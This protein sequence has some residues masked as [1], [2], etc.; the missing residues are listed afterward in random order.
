MEENKQ[1]DKKSIK[2]LKASKIDW[3]ELAKD[4]VCFANGKGGKILLGI[5]DGENTPPPDQE[6]PKANYDQKIQ[7]AIQQRTQNVAITVAPLTASNGG[8]YIEIKILSSSKSIAATSDGRYY[9]RVSDECQP[10]MPEDMGRLAT[11]KDAFV[12][13]LQTN[14]KVPANRV[15]QPKFY[16]IIEQIRSSE[17]VSSFF[18]EKSDDELLEEYFL[19]NEEYLTNL[20]V[21]WIGKRKD[22][23]R[24]RYAP[25]L[26]FIRYDDQ[27][28][29]VKKLTWDDFSYNPQELLESVIQDIPDWQESFE[30]P[31]GIFRTD[32]PHFE[33]EVIRELVAN[34]LVH[35]NYAMQGDI[36]IN[37]YPDHLEIHSPGRLPL[38]V[39][40]ENILHKSVRR[41]EHLARLFY[42]LGLMEREG[43]GYDKVYELLL[44][45]GRPVPNVIDKD[46]RLVVNIK[47]QIINQEIIKL[48]EK[49]STDFQLRQREVI[50]LGLIAQHNVISALDLSKLLNQKDETGLKDWLGRLRELEIIQHKGKK[51][52]TEYFVNPELLKKVNFKGK[53]DLKRIGKPRLK[54]LILEDLKIYSESSISDIHNRVGPELKRRTVKQAIDEMLK[55]E[56]IDTKGAKRWRR[57]F[58]KS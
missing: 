15:D 40:P 6:I 9:M 27:E 17:R 23:A 13:E 54:E 51:R 48:I 1:L 32:I 18:K 19:K 44:S 12:W 11:E 4:C 52:S 30:I 49:A 7:K 16:R 57:Y 31:E 2:T 33:V 29:K 36:F 26:Q 21:L 55:E 3:G 50:S 37:L 41:N 34:A 35:R 53:T 20:G 47:K 28:K 14:L 45:S 58:V 39:T 24:L 56:K 8:E 38:G 5:E 42:D 22:R 10:V 43:S 46:D 25:C